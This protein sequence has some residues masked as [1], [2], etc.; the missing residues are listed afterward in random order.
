MSFS[1]DVRAEIASDI[2]S[3]GHCRNASMAAILSCIGRFKQE[4]DGSIRLFVNF[5]GR[6]SVRKLF[7]LI[8]KTINIGSVLWFSA[9]P[10]ND[11]REMR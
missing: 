6:D 8:R 10:T 4:S 11:C 5:D 2:P 9:D 1:S 7:T 3:A